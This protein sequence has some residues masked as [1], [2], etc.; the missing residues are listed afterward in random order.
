MTII[1]PNRPENNISGGTTEIETIL[2]AFATAHDSLQSRLAEHEE[3]ATSGPYSFLED[4]VGG[5][6][7][8]YEEQRK[9]LKDLHFGLTGM[10]YPTAA[11][12][13]PPPPPPAT[14]IQPPPPPPD[15]PLPPKQG[16]QSQSRFSSG[17]QGAVKHPLPARPA[18]GT[19]A[20]VSR[21]TP[22]GLPSTSFR[23]LVSRRPE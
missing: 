20:S 5:D 15:L 22:N 18:A 7:G 13:P 23:T 1:D 11:R 17:Q 9:T 3:R 14:Q 16:G 21:S 19:N 4:I 6:F 10:D 8:S 2:E 12:R